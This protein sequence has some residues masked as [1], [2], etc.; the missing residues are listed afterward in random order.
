MRQGAASVYSKVVAEVYVPIGLWILATLPFMFFSIFVLMGR[1]LE[2]SFRMVVGFCAFFVPLGF[3]A[4]HPYI[5]ACT[6]QFDSAAGPTPSCDASPSL[7][8]ESVVQAVLSIVCG[9]IA[10][11]TCRNSRLFGRVVTGAL[12]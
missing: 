9:L 3:P 1:Q 10:A 5:G 12:L 11:H 4:V 2:T 6:V 8:V 7:Q